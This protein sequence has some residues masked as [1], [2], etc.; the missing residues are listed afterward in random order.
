MSVD[1]KEQPQPFRAPRKSNQSDSSSS[2]SEITHIPTR[3]DNNTDFNNINTQPSANQLDSDDSDDDTSTQFRRRSI[4][5]FDK[6]Y[7]IGLKF[8]DGYGNPDNCTIPEEN[9]NDATKINNNTTERNRFG[10]L[11]HSKYSEQLNAKG[12]NY[13][14]ELYLNGYGV[15][16]DYSKAM[17]WFLRSANQGNASAQFNIGFLYHNGFGIPRDCLQAMEWYI[18]SAD[19]GNTD[20]Q[21]NIGILYHDGHG[22]Q[23]D[24]LKA[25]EWYTKSADQGNASAQLNIG[26]LY[27]GGEGVQ[28]DYAKALEW[29]LKSANQGN[30]DAQLN[31]GILYRIGHGV[32]QDYTEAMEWFLKSA[33]QE[34]AD[35][36]LNVGI[37]YRFGQGVPEDCSK[38]MEWYLKSANQGNVSAKKNYDRLFA[39]G[40]R[41]PDESLKSIQ[42]QFED[43]KSRHRLTLESFYS[44]HGIDLDCP[45]SY[46]QSLEATSI[47][48][49]AES[50]QQ[51]LKTLDSNTQHDF[52]KTSYWFLEE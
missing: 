14:G 16:Q 11:F 37:L 25:L 13:L 12:Q 47:D 4:I 30:A 7:S 44:S 46:L 52:S 43:S 49:I 27:C 33:F 41:V 35:A 18:K 50:H 2:E 6:L 28:Q 51:F 23:Q 29:Y 31:I 42:K 45:P 39:D 22:V 19:Q 17:E 32:P 40:H 24:Y 1:N 8:E 48:A 34:N 36:Q 5:D 21:L 38:A 26:A 15:P 9:D 10:F 3:F 20:A